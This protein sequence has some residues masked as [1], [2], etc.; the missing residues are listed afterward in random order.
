MSTKNITHRR[1]DLTLDPLT[2]DSP[3]RPQLS[4]WAEEA[5]APAEWTV[6]LAI[7]ALFAQPHRYVDLSPSEARKLAEVLCRVAD[8]IDGVQA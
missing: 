5:D 3:H 2:E 6:S 8:D 7:G 1:L 4:V